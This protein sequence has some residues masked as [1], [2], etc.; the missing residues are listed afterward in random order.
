MGS[1]DWLAKTTLMRLSG[2][3]PRH[4]QRVGDNAHHALTGET[5]E[6]S[7]SSMEGVASPRSSADKVN[8]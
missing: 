2:W 1:E 6:E 4:S 8:G 5:A 7:R 3:S